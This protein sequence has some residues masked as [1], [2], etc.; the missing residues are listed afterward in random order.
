MVALEH[1]RRGSPLNF[2]STHRRCE[3][4]ASWPAVKARIY[5]GR[6]CERRERYPGECSVNED[7]NGSREWWWASW[8]FTRVKYTLRQRV[9][10]ILKFFISYFSSSFSLL[11]SPLSFFLLF[12]FLIRYRSSHT[13]AYLAHLPTDY[14]FE[15]VRRWYW[16]ISTD[17][18]FYFLLLLLLLVALDFNVAISRLDFDFLIRSRRENCA[19][20]CWIFFFFEGRGVRWNNR[21]IDEARFSGN[22]LLI[23]LWD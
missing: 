22:D 10:F 16:W 15:S 14:R 9:L 23:R 11:F 7:L 2:F 19:Y 5:G 1:E 6:W 12:L 4:S 20:V 17:A 8:S 13:S 18:D 3:T 21:D